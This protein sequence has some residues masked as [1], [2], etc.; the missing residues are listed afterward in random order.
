MGF[1]EEPGGGA[2]RVAADDLLDAMVLAGVQRAWVVLGHDKWDVPAYLAGGH[3]PPPELAFLV[4]RDSPSTP[5]TVAHSAPWV[6]EETVLFGFPDILFQPRDAFARLLGRLQATAAEVVLGL[7]PANRPDKVDMVERDEEGR[8]RR[9]V[10]KPE[11][12]FL[13]RA[14]I[15]A[16]WGPAFTR[17]LRERAAGPA[18]GRER[19]VGDV[20]N[21]A[22][23]EGFT[24]D[25]V[26]F[27]DGRFLDVGTVEELRTALQKPPL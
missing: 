25:T 11:R 23:D 1:V 27:E 13:D 21:E 6:A 9:I 4:L 2:V 17:F 24:I 12:T 7:F 5:A 8:A 22:L 20:L 16:A 3:R 10:I 19:Y 26:D 14:W 15:I 18:P